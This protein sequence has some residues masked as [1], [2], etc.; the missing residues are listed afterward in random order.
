MTGGMGFVGRRL[1][2][3]LVERGAERVVNPLH[4]TLNPKP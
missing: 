2:E 4:G 1:V 3:M